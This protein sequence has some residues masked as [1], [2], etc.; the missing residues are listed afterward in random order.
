[1]PMKVPPPSSHSD[2]RAQNSSAV[3]KKARSVASAVIRKAIGKGTTMGWMGWLPRATAV[4][5]CSGLRRSSAF[6]VIVLSPRG[7][8]H[9]Q[10]AYPRRPR[11]GGLLAAG[12]AALLAGCGR[13]PLST[14]DPASA[15]A[16]HVANVWWI[17][18]WGSLSVL[19][20][21]L[22]LVFF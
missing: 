14:L 15:Q 3:I 17:M 11:P 18:A 5:L 16:E 20:M 1:T 13:A 10:A 8:A 21:M 2:K 12:S 19:L 9:Q 7:I 6:M 4:W 22:A